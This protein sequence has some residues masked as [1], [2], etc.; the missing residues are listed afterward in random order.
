MALPILNARTEPSDADLIRL[1][2]RTDAAWIGHVSEGEQL[3]VGTAY[4]NPALPKI[5][6]ANHV[7]DAALSEGMTPEQ[8]VAEV[9]AHYAARGTTCAYWV[10]NP[11]ADPPRTRPLAD[12][13]LSLGHRARVDEILY[14]RCGRFTEAA[15]PA[16][17][18]II[19]ARASYR[20]ARAL[21]EE[22]ARERWGTAVDELIEADILDIDDPHT[23]TLLALR[24]DRS[25]AT[26]SVLAVGDL[27]RIENVYVAP[28]FRRR[29][30]GRTMMSR[31][32]EVCARSMF[33]HVFILVDPNNAPAAELY[34]SVGFE[35]VGELISYCA[36]HVL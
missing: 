12:H 18:K 17:L 28:D 34:R 19:P 25:A 14:L 33:R 10:M 24:D 6:N 35:P 20:H 11:S 4:T 21:A 9:E 13:L 27:G 31:A 30:V 36:P 15:P 7:R 26:V 29:G 1:F 8:A 22:R 2:H 23:D 5:W 3:E 16:G 32:L